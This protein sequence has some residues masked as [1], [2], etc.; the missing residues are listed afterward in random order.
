[1][2]PL[3]C[4]PAVKSVVS[5]FVSVTLAGCVFSWPGF[6][7]RSSPSS[8]RYRSDT[9]SKNLLN[10]W[11]LF[12]NVSHGFLKARLKGLLSLKV[13]NFSF[14]CKTGCDVVKQLLPTI[15]LR[16]VND[17]PYR[18][19]IDTISLSNLIISYR[20]ITTSQTLTCSIS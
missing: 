3:L 7:F 1:V 10:F 2:L 17:N 14:K 18:D 19:K 9:E 5:P 20:F 16:L 12:L 13:R 6:L 4:K 11:P 8:C 15:L